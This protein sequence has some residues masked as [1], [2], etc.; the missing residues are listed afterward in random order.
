MGFLQGEHPRLLGSEPLCASQSVTKFSLVVSTEYPLEL[1]FLF[2]TNLSE[3][4]IKTLPG[5]SGKSV[6]IKTEHKVQRVTKRGP[7]NQIMNRNKRFHSTELIP[8]D[9]F[10]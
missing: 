8:V 2:K 9:N 7:L 3:S 10:L 5:I 6:R 1:Y 4:G